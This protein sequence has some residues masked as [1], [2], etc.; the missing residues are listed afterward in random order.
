[1]RD[2]CRRDAAAEEDYFDYFQ[3]TTAELAQV[4]AMTN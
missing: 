1:M 4:R 3:V 2:E